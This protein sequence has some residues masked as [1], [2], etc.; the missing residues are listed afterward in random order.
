MKRVAVTGGA[1]FIGSH[2]VE[3]LASRDYHV[4]I[5]D[6]LSTGKM[7]NVERLCTNGHVDFAQESIL[8]LPVLRELLR[9]ADYVF[10]QAALASVP[11]S[12]DEP[13]LANEVNLTGTL[14]VLLAARENGARKVVFA[15]S[16]AVYG[17]TPVLPNAEDSTPNPMTPYAVTK[18]AAEHYC[19]VFTEVYEVPTV[20]LRYF[21]VY[22]PGQDANS[23]YSAAISRF[24]QLVSDGKAPVIFGDGE[25]ARDFVYVGDVVR[26]NIMAAESGATGVYNIGT[27]KSVSVNELAEKVVSA[28]G[29]QLKPVHA[30]RRAGDIRL[31]V[32]DI[33]RARAFDYLPRTSLEEGL[34]ETVQSLA[35]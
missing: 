7:A 9:D 33:S 31:S 27:G 24:I 21:N 17:D 28:M 6:D 13:K 22:G 15:S 18:L 4:T 30:A 29:R 11:L 20:C 23:W 2:L 1:G 14:N 32:A 3:E 25:Q 5:V 12:I 8:N 19:R 16:A 26:A 10:H 35:G 34:S